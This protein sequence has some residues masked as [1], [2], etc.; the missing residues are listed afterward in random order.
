MNFMMRIAFTSFRGVSYGVGRGGIGSLRVFATETPTQNLPSSPRTWAC[1]ISDRV[2]CLVEVKRWF[3][4]PEQHQQK[5][6]AKRE[7]G[8]RCKPRCLLPKG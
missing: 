7:G 2:F 6:K 5:P 4:P 1:V 8:R 3:L